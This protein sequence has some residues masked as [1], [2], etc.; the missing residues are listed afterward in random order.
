MMLSC[1][2]TSPGSKLTRCREAGQ[3]RAGARAA[4]R[5]VIG[6]A[7]TENK[8]AAMASLRDRAGPKNSIWS[9]AAPSRPVMPLRAKRFLDG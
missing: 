3:L 4:R 6:A 7:G 2:Q 9:M 8:I 5:A 1:T